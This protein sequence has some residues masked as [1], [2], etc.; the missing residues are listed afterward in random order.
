MEKHRTVLVVD[1]DHDAR[2]S[3][4]RLSSRAGIACLSARNGPE[5]LTLLR[6][7]Q[8]SAVVSDHDMPVAYFAIARDTVPPLVFVTGVTEGATYL[9]GTVPVAGC[10]TTDDAAGVKTPATLQIT[11]GDA[12]GVG[13]ITATCTGAVDKVGNVAADVSVHY[14]VVAYVFGGFE[15]PLGKGDKTVKSGS[16]VPVKFQVFDWNGKPATSTSVIAGIEFAPNAT[17]TGTPAVGWQA[18]GSSGGS[19]LRFDGNQF[20]FNW[21]TTGLSA[22]CYSI[23][24][25]TVDTLRHAATVVFR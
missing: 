10:T 23:G 7:H 2:E 20:H 22:G 14:V 8:I 15:P 21:K 11:G 24:V 1:D 9:L 13:S 18:A 17:C 4:E 25:R 3:L 16:T 19:A 5:A 12:N 6:E